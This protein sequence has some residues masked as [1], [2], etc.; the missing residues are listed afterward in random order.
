LKA[1]RNITQTGG[2][3]ATRVS[4]IGSDNPV[5]ET[6]KNT[7]EMVKHTK[8]TEKYTKKIAESKLTFD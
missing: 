3:L 6:A 2:F 1:K 7:K 4:L 5:K 8:N